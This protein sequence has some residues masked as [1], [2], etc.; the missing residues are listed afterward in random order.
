[1]VTFTEAHPARAA[2]GAADPPGGALGRG[3]ADRRRH[4]GQRAGPPARRRLAH[5]WD[6][7]KVEARRRADDP[8]AA[9]WV[10]SLGVDEHIWRPGKFGAGREVTGMV[11][12]TR[13]AN[14]QVG[15]VCSTW[16]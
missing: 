11:D 16:S 4:D 13:D 1:M 9:A 12:L 2:A 8:D 14:G 7:L 3:C 5:L 10:E 6:A 15:H